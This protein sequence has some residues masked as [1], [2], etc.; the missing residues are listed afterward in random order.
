[1]QLIRTVVIL[2][3]AEGH[4]SGQQQMS[5]TIMLAGF[6]VF[7]MVAYFSLGRRVKLSVLSWFLCSQMTP[8]DPQ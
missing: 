8:N 4:Y 1:M 2:F 5:W 6:A 3:V 7:F